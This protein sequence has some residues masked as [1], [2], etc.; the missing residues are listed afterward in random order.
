MKARKSM[1]IAVV[2]TSGAALLA[3][4]QGL[5]TA[6]S[7]P[8]EPWTPCNP[9]GSYYGIHV[10]EKLGATVTIIANDPAC[11]TF[12]CIQKIFNMDHTLGGTFPDVLAASD[13]VG[14]GVRTGPNS[15]RVTIVRYGTDG[16]AAVKYIAMITGEF[17]FPDDAS[18][19]E[20]KCTWALYLP[21][22]DKDG[23]GWP[24]EGQTPVIC[25]PDEG[26]MPRMKI[27]PTV[28][29]TPPPA[30]GQ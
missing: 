29:L 15:W 14:I 1:I 17:E 20:R 19:L 21:E 8:I 22:Q 23:D 26:L 9:A 18:A 28:P 13:T 24:D 2:V 27:L 12:S 7:D 25:I 11:N 4:G 10:V 5:T 3:V 16:A 6:S 30:P